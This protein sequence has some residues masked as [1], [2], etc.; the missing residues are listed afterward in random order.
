[1]TW[2]KGF[3]AGGA[4]PP[5]PVDACAP[6]LK[7][8]GVTRAPDSYKSDKVTSWEIGTKNR[9]FDRKLSLATSV[10]DIKWSDIQ[11]SVNLRSCSI[12][13]TGNLGSARSRGFD[14]Q[15]TI[16]PFEGLTIDAMVG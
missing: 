15:A 4:N 13:Y 12:Q 2:S 8:L 16:L 5:I 9:L 7:D 6:S 11:Q 14:V 3:R 1:A 10:Y